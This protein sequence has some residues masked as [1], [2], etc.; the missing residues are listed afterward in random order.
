MLW[1]HPAISIIESQSLLKISMEFF[2]ITFHVPSI[3][4]FLFDHVVYVCKYD[5]SASA[6]PKE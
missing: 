5:Y 4:V 1:R 6:K 3:K 2:K